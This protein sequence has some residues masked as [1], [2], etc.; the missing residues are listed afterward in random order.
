MVISEGPH[1]AQL[2]TIERLGIAPSIDLLVTSAGEQASKSDGLFE[3]ALERA[4]CKR[5]EILYVGDSVERDIAPT[6]ALGIANVYVGDDKLPDGSTAMRLDLVALARLLDQL[7]RDGSDLEG[8]ELRPLVETDA[9]EL[10]SLIEMDRDRLAQWL[11]WAANQTFDDTVR[12]IRE[13]EAQAAENN[14]FQ[15][16]VVIDGRIA[17]V[18]GFTGVDWKNR[19]T[20]LGYWLGAKSE[21]RGAMTAAVRALVDHALGVWELDRV[22]IRA[23]VENRRS[24]A[25]PERLGFRQEGTLRKAKQVNGRYFDSVVYS[26]RAADWRSQEG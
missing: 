3:K 5:H 1:D 6:S 14:G 17:G 7:A 13:S 24:R 11:W 10:H 12:F 15:A 22:E 18:I 16:A 26:M 4:G 9:E 23:A 8:L 19:A 20:R 2:T 21:G 25:I